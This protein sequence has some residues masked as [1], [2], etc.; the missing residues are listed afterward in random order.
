MYIS[1][2]GPHF[3][4]PLASFFTLFL[5]LYPSLNVPGIHAHSWDL[6]C[7]GE[8][9]ARPDAH[10]TCHML[11]V[12][13]WIGNVDT[14]PLPIRHHFVSV[15]NKAESNNYFL[16]IIFSYPANETRKNVI[17]L[18]HVNFD[19]T[20]REIIWS[21]FKWGNQPQINLLNNFFFFRVLDVIPLTIRD[22]NAHSRKCL[23]RLD[24]CRNR[25]VM[26]K[27]LPRYTTWGIIICWPWKFVVYILWRTFVSIRRWVGTTDNNKARAAWSLSRPLY[28]NHKDGSSDTLL[29]LS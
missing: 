25:T 29:R 17:F 22:I 19:R 5:A 20:V 15:C 28:I 3:S 9:R 11:Y 27:A 24:S 23:S 21:K 12:P 4:I 7:P 1:P 2:R 16:W 13:K 14:S 6:R 8:L 18:N 10:P 26:L